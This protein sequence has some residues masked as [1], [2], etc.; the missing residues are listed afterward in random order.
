MKKGTLQKVTERLYFM[1]FG[2]FSIQPN[3]TKI[4]I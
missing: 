1:Y 4:G 2:E 3:P